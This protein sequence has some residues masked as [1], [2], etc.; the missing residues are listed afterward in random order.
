MFT[1]NYSNIAKSIKQDIIDWA[2]NWVEVPNPFYDNKFPVC[3]YAKKARLD[4]ETT[5]SVYT[6]GSIKEFIKQNIEWL[7]NTKQHKQ[8]LLVFPPRTKYYPSI[9]K[10]IENQNDKL[11]PNNLFALSGIALNTKSKYIGFFN[12][13]PYFIIGINTLSDVMPAVDALES[14]GYYKNWSKKHYK[15]IVVKRKNMYEKYLKKKI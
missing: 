9:V 3:P 15:D 2:I 10:F 4:G 5:I 7:I 11:V 14:A 12:S 1:S 6:S 8:M 13:G